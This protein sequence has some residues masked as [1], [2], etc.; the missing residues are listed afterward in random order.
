MQICAEKKVNDVA[1]TVLDE[2]FVLLVLENVWEDMMSID[3]NEYYRP[4]K[5][6]SIN[7]E[8]NNNAANA[9]LSAATN[10]MQNDQSRA[11]V[12]GRWTSA[13]RGSR[14]YGGWSPEGLHCFN[15]LVKMVQQDR[16]TDMHF[17]AQYEI[18]LKETMSEKRKEKVCKDNRQPIVRAYR[19]LTSLGV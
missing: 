19:D 12:T 17:Q 1:T 18:W 11:V 16:S 3:I 5:R 10:S 14:R 8:G 2:A 4:K 9:N 15:K 7:D 6:K 13:W